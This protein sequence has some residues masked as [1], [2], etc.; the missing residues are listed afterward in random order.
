MKSSAFEWAAKYPFCGRFEIMLYK[1]ELLDYKARERAGAVPAVYGVPVPVYLQQKAAFEVK[2]FSF[3][4]LNSAI[5]RSHIVTISSQ[6]NAKSFYCAIR[7]CN[8]RWQLNQLFWELF[9]STGRKR[10][11]VSYCSCYLLWEIG[12]RSHFA[13]IMLDD[14]NFW[15]VFLS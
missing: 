1:L 7:F 13:Y 9:S 3:C 12:H 2:N 5:F 15:A 8:H 11:I 14:L 10:Y 6:Q 4:F